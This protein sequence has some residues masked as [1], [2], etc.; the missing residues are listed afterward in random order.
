MTTK[1]KRTFVGSVGTLVKPIILSGILVLAVVVS[2][3]FTK[4]AYFNG[5]ITVTLANA[6][7]VLYAKSVHLINLFPSPPIFFCFRLSFLVFK[8]VYSCV[9]L[10]KGLSF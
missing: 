1:K 8:F 4:I 3:M 6:R 5:L 2:S 7:F 10:E 9:F